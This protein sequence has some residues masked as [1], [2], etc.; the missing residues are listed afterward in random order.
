MKQSGAGIQGQGDFGNPPGGDME[1]PDHGGVVASHEGRGH[2][3]GVAL[4]LGANSATSGSY[5]D[6]QKKLW[7]F[8]SQFLKKYGLDQEPTVPQVIHGPG[9]SFSPK[10]ASSFADRAHHNHFHVEFQGG[11]LIGKS[12]KQ[13]GDMSTKAS[14]EKTGSKVMIQPVIIEKQAPQDNFMMNPMDKLTFAGRG[15][16]NN[17]PA[18]SR[19]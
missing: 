17:T 14:Y 18:F 11:G 4:D 6:D 3:N 5:Q 12:T 2:Y 16:L 9:E 1:H 19:G 13:Y 15:R 8:I 7:P 10:A